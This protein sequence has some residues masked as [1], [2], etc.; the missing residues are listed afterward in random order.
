MP[1]EMLLTHIHSL[2]PLELGS[3]DV[4]E[5]GGDLR[6]DDGVEDDAPQTHA[7]SDQFLNGGLGHHLPKPSCGRHHGHIVQA[8]EQL[9]YQINH[10]GFFLKYRKSQKI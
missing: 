5:V 2:P 6:G 4:D 7:Q 3:D 1:L 8:D 9:Q 10:S